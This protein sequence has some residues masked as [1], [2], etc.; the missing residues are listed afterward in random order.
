MDIKP[1]I[2]V[3]GGGPAGLTAAKAAADA[4]ADVLVLERDPHPGGQ[5]VK[6]THKFFGSE[7]QY[8]SVRG[9]EIARRLSDMISEHPKIDVW[10]D[11]AVLGL[12]EDGVITVDDAGRYTKVRPERIIV[13][14]GASE[15][16]ISFPNNDLPGV[17]GAGAV[18]TM[19]NVYGV[20][21][22]HRVLMVGSG[23]IGLIVSY[24]L[25][26]AGVAV[27]AVVEGLPVI[28]GYAVHASKIRRAGVP[29]LTRHTI[30]RADGSDAVETA[31]IAEIN[32]AWRVLPG[33]ERTIPC[34]VICI[35]VGLS[36]LADVLW[37]AGV[38]MRYVGALGGYV[39]VRDEHMRTTHERIFVAGDVTG[40]EEASVAMV[41][42][43]LAGLE[44]AASLGYVADDM[45]SIR[46]ACLEQLAALR[47]GPA[48]EKIRHGLAH[49][50]REEVDHA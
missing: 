19:M 30:V 44:A 34:D 32:A 4:G 40:I 7:Q 49:C 20:R 48:G 41:E 43:R 21:P 42:G 1:D 11:A 38:T 31:T 24:Q 10:T 12:Y 18:Q 33:T 35:A 13:A 47:A 23:N 26:Q 27:A 14:T 50:L 15:K 28:G 17:F 37:Q 2:A 16:F 22:G 36:P 39:P 25:L 8:A 45:A 6:Q 5:L 9:I 46:S 3:I 29:I